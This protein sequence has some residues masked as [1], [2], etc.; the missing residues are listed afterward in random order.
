MS[1]LIDIAISEFKKAKPGVPEKIWQEVTE[2]ARKQITADQL[3]EALTPIY[4][5]HYSP[6]EI[7]QLVG[8]FE[9]P[10]GK[11]WVKENPIVFRE[12]YQVGF[13]FGLTLR[14]YV[15]ERLKMKGY[16]EGI[17]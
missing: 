2:E 17:G 11:K 8:F 13:V 10:V 9:S 14:D 1:Q 6:A 3:A 7:K 4:V 15:V 5:R 16:S 12:S